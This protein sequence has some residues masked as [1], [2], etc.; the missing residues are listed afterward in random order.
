[1]IRVV[2]FTA[3]WCGPCKPVA[4]SLAELAPSYPQVEFSEIDVDADVEAGVRHDVLVLPTVIVFRDDAVV[5]RLDGARG[6]AD[7]D[8]TLREVVPAAE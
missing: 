3:P 1:M 7:Y 4:R 6:K 2:Q 8:R 5:A